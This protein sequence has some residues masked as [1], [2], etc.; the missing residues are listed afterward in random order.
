ML[1]YLGNDEKGESRNLYKEIFHDTEEF[2][3]Y[4]YHN[5][6]QNNKLLVWYQ[7]GE[8]VSMLH[9]VPHYLNLN[10]IKGYADYIYGVATKQEYRK[11]GL[12]GSLM[13]RALTDMYCEKLPFTYLVPEN[14]S[15]YLSHG[16]RYIYAGA[17]WKYSAGEEVPIQSRGYF[18]KSTDKQL[19]EELVRFSKRMLEMHKDVYLSR[20]A[21]YYY[22]MIERLKV[23]NGSIEL[24]YRG[25]ALAGYCY[26][27]NEGKVE[28]PEFV[29]E[30]Q[31]KDIFIKLLSE[32]FKFREANISGIFFPWENCRY[33]DKVMGRI[34]R[35]EEMAGFITAKESFEFSIRVEDT[36]IEHNNNVFTFRSHKDGFEIY[37]SDGLPEIR[38]DIGELA[39]WIFG[40]RKFEGLPDL[41][42]LKNVYINDIL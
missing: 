4:Y 40:Y 29:C 1:K 23:E 5:K 35:I 8:M 15:V 33:V 6:V 9:R 3:D 32:K 39:Q 41:D 21:S 31:D 18:L 27:S 30:K 36:I 13:S 20:E 38:M 34:V 26:I 7:D 22:D 10:G 14:P 28:I 11:K 12:M 16:F 17:Q 42:C 24:L 25:K 37:K 19:V 2:M